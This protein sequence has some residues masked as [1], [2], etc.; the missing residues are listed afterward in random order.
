M[1]ILVADKFPEEACATLRSMGHEVDLRPATSAEDLGA[2]LE[3]TGAQVL[4][5]R[6]T[7]VSAAALA[8]GAAL[9][10]I[11]R[12]GAGVNTIDL[13]TASQ[14]GIFVANCPGKN[15][16][17]VAELTMGLLLAI[18]RQIPD[19]V[20][21][22]R[23]GTWNKK[24][25]GKAD[26]LHGKRLGLVG[27]GSIAREVATRAQAFGLSVSAW[28]PNLTEGRAA[29]YGVGRFAEL[30]DLLRECDV[31][32]V[33]VPY[34][35][36]THHLIGAE[37]LAM[38][39]PG[40]ILLHT[41]RGGVVDDEALRA[42]AESGK[43][44]AGVDV[45]DGEPGGGQAEFDNGLAKAAGVYG[46]PH[47]GASTT[48]A[49]DA[50]ADEV[51]RIIRGYVELGV[52]HN[53]VNLVTDRPATHAIVVR[54]LDEVGVL[55]GVFDSLRRAGLNVKEMQNVIFEGN[56]AACATI[57]VEETPSAEA[58]EELR[59]HDSVIAVD[60]RSTG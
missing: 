6:S 53:A 34:S 32:S 4:V 39:K 36:A 50:T 54:H 13:K 46:T 20:A 31:I 35:D 18:D 2:A 51:I 56:A 16:I 52:V 59:G 47:I 9:S 8:A 29:S 41:A 30:E 27:F 60:L 48:Q 14:R 28:T 37:Q 25:F 11:V 38:M 23:A 58:L 40:V 26:G 19:A 17:A 7:K 43:V 57:I 24:K 22:L 12:A 33:H 49:A 21:E 15:A 44:R 45:F 1:K 55:A 5:V 10:L 42:A 3:Q